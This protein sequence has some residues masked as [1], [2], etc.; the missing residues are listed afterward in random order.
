[1]NNILKME[2]D[3]ILK[4]E[5]PFVF[6]AFCLNIIELKK[7]PNY[8]VKLPV[9]MDATCSGIQ[10]LA[11]IMRDIILASEVN[12]TIE[13]ESKPPK[14]IYTN[15]KEI[16]NYNI[17]E[18]GKKN[19]LFSSFMFILLQRKHIKT[20]V[21]TR[22]YNVT[23]IGIKEQLS[24][25]FPN[26]KINNETYYDL[27]RKTQGETVRINNLE[28][29]KI[30]EIIYNSIFKTYPSLEIVYKYFIDMTKSMNKVGIPVT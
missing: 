3:F 7:N 9:F 17:N 16:I 25:I 23:I 11:A 14:D 27:P 26:F 2:A 4:A 22:V 28:L 29:Y 19:E 18:Y 13:D 30:A 1:M 8:K 21:M 5:N 10:H 12:L 24:N 15:L 6:A 20:S